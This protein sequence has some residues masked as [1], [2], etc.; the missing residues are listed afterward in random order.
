MHNFRRD[1]GQIDL[2]I[3]NRFGPM[4]AGA[5]SSF[6]Y[7]KFDEFSHS[8]ALGQ[9]AGTLDYIFPRGRVGIFGTKGFMDGSIL[10]TRFLAPNRIEETLPEHRR[11]IWLQHRCGCLG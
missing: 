7:V 6:K 1:E 2:G 11:S 9:A 3:V 8:G 5:F 10:N 4:Q